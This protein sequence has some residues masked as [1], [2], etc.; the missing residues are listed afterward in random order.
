MNEIQGN[1]YT[2][3]IERE[4]LVNVYANQWVLDWVKKYHPNIFLTAKDFMEKYLNEN[5]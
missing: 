2:L 3:D 1:K 4:D 5:E